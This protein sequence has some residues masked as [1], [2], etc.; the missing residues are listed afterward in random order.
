MS[1][2]LSSLSTERTPQ[3]G[4][5]VSLHSRAIDVLVLVTKTSKRIK[6]L[7]K[8]CYGVIQTVGQAVQFQKLMGM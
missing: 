7:E 5:K 3:N 4:R 8:R 1:N 6:H 2:I